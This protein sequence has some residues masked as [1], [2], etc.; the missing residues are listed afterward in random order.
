MRAAAGMLLA[1]SACTQPSARILPGLLD[2][3][4]TPSTQLDPTCSYWSDA[5]HSMRHPP[6]AAACV[7]APTTQAEAAAA[8]YTA[9]IAQ[10]G[11]R[12]ID[13]TGNARL[14]ERTISP[15]CKQRVDFRLYAATAPSGDAGDA[16]KSVFVFAPHPGPVCEARP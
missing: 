10:A 9:A 7:T 15:G 3:P 5:E 8:A 12:A 6:E 1:L 2:L 16:P 14:Y 11:W 13:D 4:V